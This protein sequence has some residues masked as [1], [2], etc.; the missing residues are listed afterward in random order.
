MSRKLAAVLFPGEEWIQKEPNIWIAKSR[1]GGG[2]KEQSK[3]Y[4][5]I[6]NVRLLTTQGS[7]AYFL[8]EQAKDEGESEDEAI[9][10]MHADTVID[11]A[12]VELKNISGN[13]AT[14]GKSFRRGYK[15]GR[16]L[17]KKHG[18]IAQHSVFLRVYTPFSVDSVKAK[19]AG[20]L[21]NSTDEGS[22]ICFFEPT[23]KLYFWTYAELR[24][25]VGT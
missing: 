2:H 15:Q 13:R 21:K 7:V 11:G 4:R 12:V 19:L 22:C 10:N 23:E 6:S 5:E 16:S 25:I 24:A 8:P 3:L 20:E 1:L 18:I 17:L 14:L 9:H